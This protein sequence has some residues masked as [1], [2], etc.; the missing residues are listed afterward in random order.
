M[1]GPT[2]SAGQPWAGRH[3]EPNPNADDDGS[4]PPELIDA[5]D[6]FHAGQADQAAVVDVLR[7]ARVLIPLLAKAGELGLS[8]DGKLIDKTQ[9]LA[10]VTVKGPDGRSVIPVF[11]SVGAMSAW[12]PT[13]RPVPATGVRV[14]LAAA[15][16]HTDLVVLDPTSPTEFGVRRPAL[17]SMAKQQPWTPAF[18]DV[19]VAAEFDRSVA[20][21]PAVV[22]LQLAP[23]DPDARLAGPELLVVLTLIDGLDAEQ[24]KSLFARLNE[25]WSASEL[26]AERVDSVEVRLARA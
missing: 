4:A 12:N 9:E 21:E 11:S 7:D 17:W 2:D 20:D 8:D 26:I 1:T 19:A 14:A 25:R 5:I 18:S 23:G 15:S 22:A 6:R 24:L 3:F 13:A 10:I 16:E